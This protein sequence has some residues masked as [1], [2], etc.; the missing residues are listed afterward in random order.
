MYLFVFIFDAFYS[1]GEDPVL[2]AYSAEVFPLSSTE[3]RMSWAVVTTNFWASVPSMA[4]ARTLHAF[5][6]VGTLGFCT[7]LNVVAFVMV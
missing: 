7:G 1:P 4:L 2:F 5:T 6:S 3:V